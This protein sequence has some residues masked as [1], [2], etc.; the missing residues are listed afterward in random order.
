V[1]GIAALLFVRALYIQYPV[2]LADEA[3]YALHATFLNN[4]RF[5]VQLPNVLFFL[6]YH[7]ASWFGGNHFAITKL[8]NAIVFALSL[9]PLYAIARE[10][11]SN[12]GAYLFAV[13]VV[14]SPI[15]SYTAYV[16]PEAMFFFAFW[17]LAYVVLVKLPANI[18]YGGVYLGFAKMSPPRSAGQKRF[19]T[20]L[21]SRNIEDPL[22]SGHRM[23]RM[24]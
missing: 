11:L 22:A 23:F 8:L 17:V 3:L 20:Y 24:L 2:I 4:P 14:L 15:S 7:S 18:I 6:I 12:T 13:A 9:V 21:H 5:A 19:A 16:M 1:L 10:F